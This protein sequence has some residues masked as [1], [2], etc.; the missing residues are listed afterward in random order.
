MDNGMQN[1]VANDEQSYI[2]L[3]PQERVIA[4][5]KEWGNTSDQITELTKRHSPI[6]ALI[7]NLSSTEPVI[8]SKCAC[9]RQKLEDELTKY[10]PTVR[11]QPWTPLEVLEMIIVVGKK[12]FDLP[13][14]LRECFSLANLGTPE[15]EVA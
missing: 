10:M 13:S 3:P 6:G 2:Q 14:K 9:H 1:S 7:C 5:L 8:Q 11:L 15:A 4:M 12:K